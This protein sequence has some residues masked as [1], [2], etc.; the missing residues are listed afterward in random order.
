[1]RATREA[2]AGP[3]GRSAPRVFPLP[4]LVAPWTTGRIPSVK[5]CRLPWMSS[6]ALTFLA[7]C[8]TAPDQDAFDVSVV[9]LAGG[10]AT[11]WETEAIVTV[12]LQNATPNEITVTG[13]AHKL[14]LNG[15]YV[16][17]GLANEVVT[18]P[19]L[20]TT[21]QNITVHLKNFT[22]VRKLMG[23]QET[24]TASYKVQSTIYGSPGGG[25]PQSFRAIKEGSI[26]LDQILPP[27]THR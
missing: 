22:V 7:G 12:R 2:S 17:Q 24:R 4:P 14:Y 11:L 16:G 18:V 20:G 19:R 1:M 8:V 27:P 6:L 21:T 23:V 15:T 25:T 3:S 26:N 10:N 9:N 13:A 5:Y